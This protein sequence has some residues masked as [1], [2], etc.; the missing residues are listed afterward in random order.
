LNQHEVRFDKVNEEIQNLWDAI[1]EL[2]ERPTGT[3]G[4]EI[5]YSLLCSKE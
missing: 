3:G 1:K 5:D 2:R 4:G